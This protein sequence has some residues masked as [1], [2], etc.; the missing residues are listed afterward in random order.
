[1]RRTFALLALAA[2][3][4]TPMPPAAPP[5]PSPVFVLD[6]DRYGPLRG[7]R[8]VTEWRE[9]AVEGTPFRS[10]EERELVWDL[11]VRGERNGTAM[12]QRFRRIALRS[13]GKTLVDVRDPKDPPVIDMHVDRAGNVT[14]I[15]GADRIAKLLVAGAVPD[16]QKVVAE[17]FAERALKTYL[18]GRFDLVYRDIIGRPTQPGATWDGTDPDDLLVARHLRVD[19]LE[20]CGNA[21]CARIV[22]TYDVDQ[23]YAVAAA[24]G[25]V[26]AFAARNG[27]DPQTLRLKDVQAKLGDV[28]H[29]EP[30]GMRYHGADFDE[31]LRITVASADHEW[32]VTVKG[33]R[34]VVVVWK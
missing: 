10:R 12:Q 4:C 21:Q 18:T 28:I 3:A 33:Q 23:R 30:T 9:L 11:E 14:G 6:L 15:D 24:G 27:I 8:T 16:S 31:D 7:E 19:R 29:V 26:A 34:R 17:A 2:V 25:L 32:R 22:A 20:P 13:D 5:A 1:M